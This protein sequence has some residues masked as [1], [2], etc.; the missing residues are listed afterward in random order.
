MTT[1]V[2]QETHTAIYTDWLLL[3]AETKFRRSAGIVAF[4]LTCPD[5]PDV[6]SKEG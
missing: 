5:P 4:R 6:E 1:K 2:P 3:L